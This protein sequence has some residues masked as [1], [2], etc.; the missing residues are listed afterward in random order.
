MSVNWYNLSE[1][2][3]GTDYVSRNFRLLIFFDP[4]F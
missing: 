3:N 1:K 2:Q 4:F